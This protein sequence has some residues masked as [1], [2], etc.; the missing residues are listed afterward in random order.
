MKAAIPVDH[1]VARDRQVF[2]DAGR[3]YEKVGLTAHP[4]KQQRQ[5]AHATVLGA[6]IDGVRGRV[7]APRAR[8][9]V[10][11]FI[12][13]VVVFKG[14]ASRKLLQALIG[15]WTHVCLFRR[16]LFSILNTVYHEGDFFGLDDFFKLSQTSKLELLMLCILGPVIQTDLRA[17][18]A[19]ELFML[20]ASPYG[21]GICRTAFAS[22]G[23]EEFWRHSEQR[24]YYTK[25]M[26]GLSMVLQELGLAQ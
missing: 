7:S 12:T 2:E 9:A 6:E 4:G 23:V 13:A 17:S 3:A 5:V 25:L 26:Q 19:P 15:C 10:L 8:I 14:T 21:A 1:Q 11:A 22:V 24:G 18:V 20:D 16:P